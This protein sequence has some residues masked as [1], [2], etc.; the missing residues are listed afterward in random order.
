MDK[1][2]AFLE[3]VRLNVRRLDKRLHCCHASH[4]FMLAQSFDP[5]TIPENCRE[6]AQQFVGLMYRG[7]EQGTIS[8]QEAVF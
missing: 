4:I 3:E 8:W 1:R 2:K 7:L 5:D 6:A